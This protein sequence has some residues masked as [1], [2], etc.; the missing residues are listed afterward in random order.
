VWLQIAGV[1][2]PLCH[3]LQYFSNAHKQIVLTAVL[4]TQNSKLNYS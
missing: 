1:T 2:Y 4:S 3:P